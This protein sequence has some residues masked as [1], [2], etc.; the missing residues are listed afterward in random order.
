MGDKLKSM[1]YSITVKPIK[2]MFDYL[3]DEDTDRTHVAM[4]R[5]VAKEFKRSGYEVSVWE[6]Y[7]D[8]GRRI[9]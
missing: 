6:D 9:V 5:L 7:E 1:S 3:S 2:E 8:V 4:M